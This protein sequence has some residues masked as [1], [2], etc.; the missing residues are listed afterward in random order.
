MTHNTDIVKLI[1]E[2]IQE[3]KGRQITH[4]DLSANESAAASHFIICQG[5]STM[6]VSAIADSVREYLLEHGNRKPYNYD[7]YKNSEWIVID[8]GDTMVHVF[9]PEIRLRYNLEELWSDA[10]VEQ[11]PDLD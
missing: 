3:R 7:G 5:T 9:L 6:Q 1:T 4:I 2:G 8:Y 11:I 10:Q